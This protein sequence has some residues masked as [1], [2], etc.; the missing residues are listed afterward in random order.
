MLTRPQVS[1]LQLSRPQPHVAAALPLPDNAQRMNQHIHE[2][3]KYSQRLFIYFVSA[4]IAVDSIHLQIL[5]TGTWRQR[6]N[7]FT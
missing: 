5:L 7:L 1:R 2:A 4:A 3:R 6:G